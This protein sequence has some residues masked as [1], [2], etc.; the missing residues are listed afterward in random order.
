[1]LCE[2]R[3][4][5]YNNQLTALSQYYSQ[6]YFPR[7]SGDREKYLTKIKDFFEII[8]PKIPLSSYV[9]DFVI[10]TDSNTNHNNNNDINSNARVAVLE[11]NPFN[12]ATGACLFDW[13][14][15][16]KVLKGK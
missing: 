2:F 16:E 6:C 1:M 12:V 4:F 14:K 9:I 8:Q 10:V 7:L 5:V 11:L 15:D 13:E 3:G